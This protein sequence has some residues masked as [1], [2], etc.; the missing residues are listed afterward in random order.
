MLSLTSL[1]SIVPQVYRG[2]DVESAKPSPN[3]KKG[4][5]ASSHLVDILHP[6]EDYSVGQFFEEARQATRCI[7]DNG[8]VPVV[9]GGNGLY[10]RWNE[11]WDATVQLVVKVGDPKAQFLAVNDWYQLRCSLEII[12]SSGPPPSAFRVPY[13]SFREQGEY[14]VAEGSESSDM[15]T[16]GDAMEETILSE[17]DYEFI[18][19]FLSSHG[20][21]LYKSI[22]YQCEDMLLGTS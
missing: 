13:D 8:R 11:D 20:L 5:T 15:N 17:L 10:L 7:L 12:K 14:G 16:Y 3:E 6:S 19:F 18:C 2:L 9:F 22:D 4:G 1:A 21:D